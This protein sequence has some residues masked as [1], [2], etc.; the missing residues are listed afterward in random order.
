M[1]PSSKKSKKKKQ[2]ISDDEKSFEDLPDT[3]EE[4]VMTKQEDQNP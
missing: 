3:A 4:L 2:M 1:F